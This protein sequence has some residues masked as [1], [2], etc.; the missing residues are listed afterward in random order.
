M[1]E[2]KLILTGKRQLTPRVTEMTLEG[3]TEKMRPGQFVNLAV[4]GFALRRPKPRQPLFLFPVACSLLPQ[5]PVP[6]FLTRRR[7]SIP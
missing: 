3:V 7:S 6:S 4:P 1:K 2:E 5:K